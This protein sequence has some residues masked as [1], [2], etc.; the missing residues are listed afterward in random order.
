MRLALPCALL[1]AG[2]DSLEGFGAAPDPL[3]A[4][5]V[6]AVGDV[7]SQAGELR[8]ALVWGSQWLP[9]PFCFLPPESPEAAAVIAAGCRDI[10]GFTP[11]RVA[12]SVA[13][14]PGEVALLEVQQLPSSDV[15]VGD[16]TARVAYGSFVLFV[17]GNA[18]GTLDLPRTNRL[19]AGGI[20]GGPDEEG[21]E[22]EPDDDERTDDIVRG[23]SFVSMT[24]PD[25]RLAFREGDFVP[26]GFYP[27]A[28]CGA[29][30]PGFSVV[31]AGGFTIEEA[32]AA[33]LAGE[34][35]PQDPATCAEVDA[36]T[37]VVEIAVR[38]TEEVREV[39]CRQRGSNS[40]VRYL[41]PPVEAPF[42]LAT[43]AFAC[44]KIPQ[45]GEPDPETSAIV[46]LVVENDPEGV[47]KGLTHYTLVGCDG[48]YLSCDVP[49]WDYRAN[50]P[51]WWPCPEAL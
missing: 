40:R 33:T 45:L 15:M 4:I 32:V 13:V 3:A 43:R 5:A 29:P 20:D 37:A 10:L 7:D 9:E 6:R 23:A 27:R 2:C 21:M 49:E 47:C 50:P 48:G 44:A 25:A 12:Q 42:D 41:D 38:P 34:L 18:D 1:L 16:V 14:T 51:A 31:S 22:D 24:E 17:D 36:A 30:L 39:A 35:P 28:N 26:S 46:Q 8:V 11:A 19:P